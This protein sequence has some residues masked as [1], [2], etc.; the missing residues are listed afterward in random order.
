MLQSLTV[1]ELHGDEGFAMLVVDFVNRAD[2]GMVQG[3]SG[4]RLALETG[5]GLRIFGNFVGQ[6]LE[7]DK[8]MQLDV[9][10]FVDHAHAA[11]AEFLDD[12][13]VRNGLADHWR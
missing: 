5:E 11:A 9:L 8:A 13:V 12:A 6:E 2:V 1:E 4:L 7:R 10:G 3:G